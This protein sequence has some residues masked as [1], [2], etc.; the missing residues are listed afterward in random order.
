MLRRGAP[1][2]NRNAARGF[3]WRNAL[4]WALKNYESAHVAKGAALRAIAM[5]LVDDAIR[6]DMSAVNE[7]ANRLDGKAPSAIAI[8]QDTA[9]EVIHR[10]V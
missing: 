1:I 4:D 5:Q 10:V 6:G 3:A 2:G 8:A 9:V 7:I